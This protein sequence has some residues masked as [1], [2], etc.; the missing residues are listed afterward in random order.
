[1]ELGTGLE[2]KSYEEQLRE[3]GFFN[4]EEFRDDLINLNNYL[5]GNCSKVGVNLFSQAT[6]D[7]MRGNGPEAA[8]GEFEPIPPCPITAVP[9]EELFSSLLVG[10]FQ[11]LEGVAEPGLVMLYYCD[12]MQDFIVAYGFDEWNVGH[13]I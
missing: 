11:I 7:R 5:K 2:G 10:P 3:L 12:Q 6:R 13:W 1:M 8:L 9:D 4:L